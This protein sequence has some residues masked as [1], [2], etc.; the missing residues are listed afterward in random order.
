MAQGTKR[1]SPGADVEKNPLADVEL[2][3]EQAAKLQAVT[4][5]MS[6]VELLLERRAQEKLR[7]V[8]EKRREICKNI[9]KFWPVALLNHQMFAL[10]AQH[11]TDQVALSYLEDL[12]IERDPKEPRVFT[13]EFYFKENPYFSNSVLKKEYK[14]IPPPS[15]ANEVP[16]EDGITDSVL[17]FSWERDVEAVAFKIDWK[18]DSKNLTKLYPRETTDP[19]DDM[20]SE[21][22][23][24]FNYFESAE[25]PYDLG[26]LIANEVFPEAIDYFLGNMSGGDLDDSEDE[27]SGDSD[28]DEIDLEKPKPKKPKTA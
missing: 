22:G 24:F 25:D 23:S 17:D 28:E 4:K 18:D 2:N 3:D 12:W 6:R 20:P 1:A 8:Y 13:V 15:A 7:P 9:S 21:G 14:Y 16:D 11:Q 5:E 27:D 19:D 10:H 26:V